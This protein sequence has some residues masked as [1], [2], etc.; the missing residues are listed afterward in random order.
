MTGC[1]LDAIKSYAAIGDYR[2]QIPLDRIIHLIVLCFIVLCFIVLFIPHYNI[3][4][5]Q[6]T[7]PRRGRGRSPLR[8]H[9]YLGEVDLTI[10]RAH[11]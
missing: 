6:A 7:L 3:W 10:T 5:P 2:V 4:W 11:L 1:P 8:L 9:L